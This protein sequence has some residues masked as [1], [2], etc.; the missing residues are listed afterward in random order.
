MR[1]YRVKSI[2]KYHHF[3]IDI[4]KPGKVYVRETADGA[5]QE[6]QHVSNMIDLLDR[7]VMPPTIPPKGLSN[8]RQWYLY[9]KICPENF[10]DKTCPLPEVPS[11]H[12]IVPEEQKQRML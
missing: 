6:I 3:H 10:K 7:H 2:T 4:N 11:V 8:E 5:V 9:D 1:Y 12:I